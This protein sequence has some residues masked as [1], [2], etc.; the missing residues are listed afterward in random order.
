MTKEKLTPEKITEGS[1]FAEGEKPEEVAK[2][3]HWQEAESLALE[4]FDMPPGF[5]EL[6]SR[7]KY[8]FA[9]KKLGEVLAQ[10][11]TL[12]KSNIPAEEISNKLTE[13]NERRIILELFC[14]E[15][16]Q[17]MAV[18]ERAMPIAEPEVVT[19]LDEK[20]ETEKAGR[21][22]EEVRAKEVKEDLV[23]LAAVVEREPGVKSLLRE[24]IAKANETVA[25]W[26]AMRDAG[27]VRGGPEWKHWMDL[28]K[29]LDGLFRTFPPDVQRALIKVD[30]GRKKG[31]EAISE[32]LDRMEEKEVLEKIKKVA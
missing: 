23:D 29:E 31:R 3:V 9:T 27:F 19:G 21:G 25:G 24:Y 5:Q 6:T 20:K 10:I 14:D 30:I 15:A 26:Q 32:M 17:R 11:E 4:G 1:W 22:A 12:A 16:R 18:I 13:L 28:R 7:E 8:E 2:Q